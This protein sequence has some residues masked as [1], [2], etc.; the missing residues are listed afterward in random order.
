[1]PKI[2]LKQDIIDSNVVFFS[3]LTSSRLQKASTT[4]ENLLLQ[5]GPAKSRCMRDHGILAD[6]HLYTGMCDGQ[7]LDC[8]HSSHVLIKFLISLSNFGHQT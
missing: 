4:T 5:L 6:S 3:T 1:M 8:W 7:A 2:C